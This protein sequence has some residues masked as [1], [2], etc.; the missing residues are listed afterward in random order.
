MGENAQEIE[1]RIAAEQEE[2]R[3]NAPPR[4]KL[5]DE[6]AQ[7]LAEQYNPTAMTRDQYDAFLDDLIE[8]GALS[9]LDAAR[10][11]YHGLRVLD[12]EPDENGKVHNGWAYVVDDG[13]KPI[14]TLEDAGSDLFRWLE[15]MLDQQEQGIGASRRQKE[16]L[17]VLYDIV[18][19]M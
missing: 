3:K 1:K 4:A 17:N 5:S 10:L 2:A 13:S 11:G 15:A 6:D 16:A 8:A 19:R 12:M 18:K 9:R 7:E 14:E